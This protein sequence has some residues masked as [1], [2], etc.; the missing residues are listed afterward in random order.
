MRASQ[1]HEIRGR[2]HGAVLRSDGAGERGECGVEDDTEAFTRMGQ[3][4]RQECAGCDVQKERIW[5]VR[6][7]FEW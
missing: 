7:A 1:D 4:A 2:G 6:T 5:K 3:T